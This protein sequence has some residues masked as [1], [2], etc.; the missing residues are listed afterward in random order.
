[1]VDTVE[2]RQEPQ[3]E[4]Q[5]HVDAMVAK[6]ENAQQEPQQENLDSAKDE[7]PEWLPEKF[8]TPEDMAKSYTELERKMQSRMQD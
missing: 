7:R 4:T 3:P 6:A 5:E 1:M 2:I 8:K